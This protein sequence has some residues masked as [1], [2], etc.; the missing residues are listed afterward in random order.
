MLSPWILWSFGSRCP[1]DPCA[2]WG[3]SAQRC[4]WSLFSW[5]GANRSFSTPG[6]AEKGISFCWIHKSRSVP[7]HFR[8]WHVRVNLDSCGCT[9]AFVVV[10]VKRCGIAP[11]VSTFNSIGYEPKALLKCLGWS[12]F[13]ELME[14]RSQSVP[15]APL[16]NPFWSE[17]ASWTTFPCSSTSGSATVLPPWCEA[18][19]LD[20]LGPAPLWS[21]THVW[22]WPPDTDQN[23]RKLP[24][25]PTMM[26]RLGLGDRSN[27]ESRNCR[28]RDTELPQRTD[29]STC[30][31]PR[32]VGL[33]ATMWWTLLTPWSK[34][35]LEFKRPMVRS[36][37]AFWVGS[38]PGLIV[39]RMFLLEHHRA[40]EELANSRALSVCNVRMG[41]FMLLFRA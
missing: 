30:I 35:E 15:L 27:T 37:L 10:Q 8:F 1:S 21:K 36:T 9:Q 25:D 26:P 2:R 24:G 39:W 41:M 18:N 40:K 33:A 28:S 38:S 17:W 32:D 4:T 29:F 22:C 13:L 12:P 34:F 11:A 5:K 14:R 16:G 6:T 19:V 31:R 20:H 7:S 3:G 23:P